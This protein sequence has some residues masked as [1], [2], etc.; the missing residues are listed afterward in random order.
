[1]LGDKSILDKLKKR[2]EI[3]EKQYN[4]FID[5]PIADLRKKLL[6]V[7][8]KISSFAFELAFSK[9]DPRRFPQD[10]MIILSQIFS[11]CVKMIEQLEFELMWDIT[12]L[13]IDEMYVTTEGMSMTFDD[14]EIPLKNSLKQLRHEFF[15][16]V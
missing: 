12:D 11:H 6:D 13:S 8:I 2:K 4:Q 15:S 5:Y 14:I 16:V 9:I 10:E 7:Y 3:T 1:M